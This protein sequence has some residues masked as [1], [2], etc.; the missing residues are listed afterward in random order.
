MK[1]LVGLVTPSTPRMRGTSVR[2][3]AVMGRKGEHPAHAWDILRSHVGPH[4]AGLRRAREDRVHPDAMRSVV[5]GH[6]AHQG[7]DSGLGGAIRTGTAW[8]GAERRR[9][10]DADDGA[11]GA[12][13]QEIA[14]RMLAA[15]EN[16]AQVGGEDAFPHLEIELVDL[17]PNV[18]P[19][20]AE[21]AIRRAERAGTRR[22][23]RHNLRLIGNV[24]SDPECGSAVFTGLGG[25]GYCAI[26]IKVEHRHPRAL[27]CAE[28]GGGAPDAAAAAGDDHGPVTHRCCSVF[29]PYTAN[30][31]PPRAGRSTLYHSRAPRS[32]STPRPG[33]SLNSII[34]SRNG[35]SSRINLRRRADPDMSAGRNSI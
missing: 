31:P 17:A 12:M 25:H 1:H 5:D 13:G 27:R 30:S 20:G 24:A 21:E 4:H 26:P 23:G 3:M 18:D 22:E 8:Q 15:E 19:S 35:G 32:I 2:S 10:G 6:A 16:T 14:H 9:R 28:Q 29:G 33:R 7:A 34:P 11:S